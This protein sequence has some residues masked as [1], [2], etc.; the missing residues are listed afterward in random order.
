M[1]PYAE[2]T[3]I[4]VQPVFLWVI[5][6]AFFLIP[7]Q[8]ILAWAAAATVHEVFHYIVIRLCGYPVW[9]IDIGVTGT[10]MQTR[11][12]RPVPELLCAAAGPIGSLCLC[13]A[14]RIFPRIAVCGYIQL[15][16]NLLPIYPNDGGRILKVLIKWLFSHH[17]SEWIFKIVNS[18]IY[19]LLL[20]GVLLVSIR[21]TLGILPIVF[22]LTILLKIKKPCKE[23]LVR[24][25]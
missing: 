24:V 12:D 7:W 17:K 9:Q 18:C 25:Q 19:S 8:W 5:A 6:L 20:L 4:T 10:V 14:A 3:D 11:L 1:A 2:R 15:L 23:R 22:G 16:F 21:Y 13:L